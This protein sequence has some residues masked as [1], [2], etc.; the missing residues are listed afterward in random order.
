MCRFSPSSVD[1]GYVHLPD[2]EQLEHIGLA[3]Y[4]RIALMALV[5]CDVAD[6]A[7]LCGEDSVPT[8]KIYLAVE[9]LASLGLVQL[10]PTRPKT[11]A[12]SAGFVAR[13]PPRGVSAA[14]HGDQAAACVA[15]LMLAEYRG[16]RSRLRRRLT[17]STRSESRPWLSRAR[18]CRQRRAWR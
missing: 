7:T 6:A 17:R 15:I 14:T 2:L 3:L 11:L 1:H 18:S 12:A 13:S 10:P 16:G 5:L 9:K 4:E 8:L